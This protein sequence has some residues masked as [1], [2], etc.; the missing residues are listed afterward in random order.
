MQIKWNAEF[1]PHIVH[2]IQLKYNNSGDL[3]PCSEF[4]ILHKT[5]KQRYAHVCNIL[6]IIYNTCICITYCLP[7]VLYRH[8]HIT[9]FLHF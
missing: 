3:D 1:C 2:N 5:E 8:I 7:F 9:Y 6:Y 4:T